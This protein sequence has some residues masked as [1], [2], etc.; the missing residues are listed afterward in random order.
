MHK[1]PEILLVKSCFTTQVKTDVRV[2]TSIAHVLIRMRCSKGRSTESDV[3][4]KPRLHGHA[5]LPCDFVCVAALKQ[6]FHTSDLFSSD[7]RTIIAMV[8]KQLCCFH[9]SDL[10]HTTYDIRQKSLK[11]RFLSYEIICRMKLVMFE[12]C[13][14]GRRCAVLHT[15]YFI[16]RM[17]FVVCRTYGNTAL[18]NYLLH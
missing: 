17:G 8:V 10:F 2:H 3:R 15:A 4:L 13:Q 11:E 16:C 1:R 6:C 9:S 14:A 18:L 12:L 7:I 5:I